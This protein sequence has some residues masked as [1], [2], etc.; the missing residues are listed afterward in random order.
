MDIFQFLF[1]DKRDDSNQRQYKS[2]KISQ[3]FAELEH[4][5]PL[6]LHFCYNQACLFLFFLKYNWFGDTNF[7]VIPNE[8][9]TVKVWFFGFYALF[10]ELL[11]N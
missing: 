8:S 11:Y 5:E 9:L 2:Q 10:T 6:S 7:L 1:T 4:P 3:L